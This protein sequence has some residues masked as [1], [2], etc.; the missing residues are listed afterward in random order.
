[1]GRISKLQLHASPLVS[2]CKERKEIIKATNYCWYDFVTSFEVYL[3]SLL[4]LGNALNQYVEEE[5]HIYDHSCSNLKFLFEEEEESISSHHHSPEVKN[6]SSYTCKH[7]MKNKGYESLYYDDHDDDDEDDEESISSS[8]HHCMEVKKKSRYT[9]K[10]HVDVAECRDRK[11]MK[12][13]SKSYV[14]LYDH[15]DQDERKIRKREEI[16]ALEDKSDQCSNVARLNANEK[17]MVGR[18]ITEENI[19]VNLKPKATVQHDSESLGNSLSLKEAVLEIK[20]EFK[21]L[22]DSKN[23]FSSIIKASKLPYHSVNSKSKGM[24][25]GLGV[26]TLYALVYKKQLQF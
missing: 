10:H 7:N 18:E 2:L 5:F 8:Y 9:C 4:E 17:V 1:M 20:N 16:P 22:F 24:I 26:V 12:N 23:E 25:S 3:N 14:V 21:H 6:E 11:Y 13:R 15:D 19:N